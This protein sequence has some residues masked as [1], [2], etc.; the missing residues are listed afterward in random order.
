MPSSSRL[1]RW[2]GPAAVGAGVLLLVQVFLPLGYALVL[3]ANLASVLLVGGL[4][5]LHVC[6][7]DDHRYGRL[8]AVGF[9]LA[10]F[11][12]LLGAGAF[13]FVAFGDLGLYGAGPPSSGLGGI[14]GVVRAGSWGL[15]A[16][17]DAGLLLLGVATLRAGVLALP[18]KALPLTIFAVRSGFL[19]QTVFVQ[20]YPTVPLV[21]FFGGNLFVVLLGGLWALLG[22]RLWSGRSEDVGRSAP[23]AR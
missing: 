4:A 22:W 10:L 11:G 2:G 7:A 18:W 23:A 15:G 8:G 17:A 14:V 21:P 3:V 9:W 6:H 16:I 13:T 20:L 1:A 19:L 5:G 12:T